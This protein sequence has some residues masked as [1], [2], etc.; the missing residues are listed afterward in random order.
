MAIAIVAANVA[1]STMA[2][3]RVIDVIAGSCSEF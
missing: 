1:A 2:D 3:R